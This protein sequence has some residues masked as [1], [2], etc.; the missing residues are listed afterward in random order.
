VIAAS[1][2]DLIGRIRL[3]RG[4]PPALGDELWFF[5]KKALR[6]EANASRHIAYFS[7]FYLSIFL[8][9]SFF[10][11][12]VLIRNYYLEKRLRKGIAMLLRKGVMK[13]YV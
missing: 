3:Y 5:A 12:F 9:I 2:E 10:L 11:F 1:E 13:R 6:G 8:S 4:V 7:N